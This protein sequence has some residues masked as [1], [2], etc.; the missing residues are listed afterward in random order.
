M[1]QAENVISFPLGPGTTEFLDDYI[2]S[3]ARRLDAISD[4]LGCLSELAWLASRDETLDDHVSSAFRS[5]SI[6]I[7]DC[8]AI[9]ELRPLES[10]A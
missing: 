7:K 9:A 1:Q 8:Q 5:L 10:R 4:R 3:H 2:G 6:S